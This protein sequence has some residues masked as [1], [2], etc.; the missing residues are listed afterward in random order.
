[1]DAVIKVG[2]SLQADPAA[3][4]NLC[5]TLKEVSERYRLLI[6]P[7][8]GSFADLECRVQTRHG[9]SDRAAHRM[10][11]LTMDIY[12]LMLHDLIGGSVLTDIPTGKTRECSIFLPFKTMGHSPELEPTWGVTSD[13][14]AALVTSKI[15]CKRLLL[16]KMVD[17]ILAHAKLK[18]SVSTQRLMKMDQHLVDPKFPETLERA[19]ITCWIVNGKHPDRIKMILDG[20]ETICTKISLGVSP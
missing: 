18:K 19:G 16:V 11:I 15:G 20:K 12:G 4:R 14:I 7:D 2:G 13:S 10:A 8:G 3:L 9:F 1:M 5:K 6:I 17:G